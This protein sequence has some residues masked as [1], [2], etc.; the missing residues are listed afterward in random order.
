MSDRSSN[1]STFWFEVPLTK[2][3]G[4]IQGQRSDLNGARVL[5]LS[6]DA[7]QLS[8]GLLAAGL[9][10]TALGLRA[11]GRRLRVTTYRPHPW[12]RRETLV[13]A[14][15]VLAS[16]VVL[17]LGWLDPATLPP[18]LAAILDPAAL[19]PTTNPLVWPSLSLPMLVVVGLV[20]APLPLTRTRLREQTESTRNDTR[21]RSLRPRVEAEPERELAW[22]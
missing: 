10:G 16:V 15:G 11:A 2:A 9:A 4:D 21:V 17:G 20:L 14:S 7:W 3:A 1:G 6:T 5:L 8:A 22:R 19:A 12:R 13:A 18:A